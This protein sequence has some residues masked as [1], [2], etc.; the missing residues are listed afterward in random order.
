MSSGGQVVITRSTS[1]ILVSSSLLLSTERSHV[2]PTFFS[3]EPPPT[4]LSLQSYF[5]LP[6]DPFVGR[7]LDRHSTTRPSYPP[8]CSDLF[9][10]RYGSPN[11][12][13]ILSLRINVESPASDSPFR[14]SI[15]RRGRNGYRPASAL[16]PNRYISW[17]CQAWR[18]SS[19][20][21]TTTEV[22]A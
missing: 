18:N 12:P 9:P 14:Y 11:F 7:C 16:H 6:L 19:I 1:F 17:S 15:V 5:S 8:T 22:Q 20:C 2:F 10:L 3:V 21:P 13:P 4:L